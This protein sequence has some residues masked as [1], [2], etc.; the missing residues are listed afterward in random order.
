MMT[1]NKL[2]Q[3]FRIPDD[4]LSKLTNLPTVNVTNVAIISLIMMNIKSDMDA[5]QF[6]D[7][8]ENIVDNKSSKAHIEGLRNGNLPGINYQNNYICILTLSAT[9]FN[10]FL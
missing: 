6:C 10:Y 4:V 8:V 7:V 3:Q 1:L 5:L 9:C 2:K